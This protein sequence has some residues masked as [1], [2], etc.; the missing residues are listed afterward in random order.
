MAEPTANRPQWLRSFLIFWRVMLLI[1]LVFGVYSVYEVDPALL[2]SWRGLGLALTLAAFLIC[3]ELYE[4]SEARRG[5]RWPVP[6]RQLLLYLAVQLALATVLLHYSATFIGPLFA[7]LGQAFSSVPPR[8]WLVPIGA[9]IGLLLAPIGALE[10]PGQFDLGG[11]IGFLFFMASWISIALFVAVLFR[12]RAE[13]ERLI[14]ELRQAKAGLE[15]AALQTEELA[16]LRER[17]RLAREMHDS[18]GHALV[19]VNVQLEA[20]Q[21]LYARDPARGD[22]ELEATRALVREAMGELR[23]SLANLRAE[24]FDAQNLPAALQRIADEVRTRG[25]LTV[26]CQ[27]PARLDAL[28]PEA[29]AALWRVAREALANVERHAS[30]SSATLALAAEPGALVLRVADNGAGIQPQQLARNGHYGITGMRERLAALGGT[31][32]IASPPGG[33]TLV[34]ARVPVL[35]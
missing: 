1:S 35:G 28:D 12:E 32:T 4:R 26:T 10:S 8:Q 25:R 5:L 14:A 9:I 6:Y 7:L 31:L 2:N 16:V 33:G 19:V 23:R 20:A 17:T 18:L 3:H 13:R 24:S 30:A 34:E 15:R 21:R 27:L 29:G 22:A 11:L